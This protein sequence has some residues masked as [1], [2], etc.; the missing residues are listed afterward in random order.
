METKKLLILIVEDQKINRDILKGILHRDYDVLEATNGQEAL[1]IV[2]KDPGIAAILLDLLMP[3]MDGYSFLS[4][5]A[6]TPY[7]MIPTIAVTGE[8]DIESEQKVLDLGAWDFV[9]KPYQP[10][11]LLTRLK[12]AISRSEYFSLGSLLINSLGVP[13]AVFEEDKGLIRVIRFSQSY[14]DKLLSSLPFSLDQ[15]VLESEFLSEKDKAA[16]QKAFESLRKNQEP[17]LL[18]LSGKEG[19]PV[20]L[21]LRYWG[22][23][24]GAMVV[25]G[26]FQVR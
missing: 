10:M 23:N 15:G 18:S 19:K 9:S 7:S 14:Q 4:A 13:S 5:I 26:E 16:L 24:R 1:E 2:R 17:L 11:T 21:T 12:H 8:N 25:F 20:Q 3:V 6:L 22:D